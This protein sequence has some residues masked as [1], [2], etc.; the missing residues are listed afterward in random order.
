[1]ITS[2]FLLLLL[3]SLAVPKL[4][5]AVI[6]TRIVQHM[7]LLFVLLLRQ[8]SDTEAL[9]EEVKDLVTL[10]AGLLIIDDTTL[11]KTLLQNYGQEV[12]TEF[13]LTSLLIYHSM[14]I[15]V[16]AAGT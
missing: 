13:L 8:P 5:S 6:L 2:T 3:E 1:M 7:T 10:D 12:L 14:M 4:L 16:T 9:W 15:F 11:D